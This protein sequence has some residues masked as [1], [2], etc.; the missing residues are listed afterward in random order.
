[1]EQYYKK[2][3]IH[4]EAD[5]PKETG[6]Y[7]VFHSIY[8]V[9][10]EFYNNDLDSKVKWLE[11]FDWYL[12]PIE[13]QKMVN[14]MQIRD[15]TDE[16][17]L[18]L[19]KEEI[20][21]LYKNCYKMLMDFTQ[22]TAEEQTPTDEEI[23][24]ECDKRYVGNLAPTYFTEG[25]KW[26]RSQLTFRESKDKETHS[27]SVIQRKNKTEVYIDGKLVEPNVKYGQPLTMEQ[28]NELGKIMNEYLANLQSKQ[29]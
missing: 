20:L 5:L 12:L 25:A 13:E 11:C 24:K 17:W 19:P 2:V 14:F 9:Q 29:K 21:Q 10:G 18:Q 23:K 4:S 26:M 28:Y 15:L 27:Y 22:K 7:F 16:E 6:G 1:M 8:G 3:V